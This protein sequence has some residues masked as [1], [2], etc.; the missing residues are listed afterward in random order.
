MGGDPDGYQISLV[1]WVWGRV[2]KTR[3]VQGQ[4]GGVGK[5]YS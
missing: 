4:R 2:L 5:T 3:Q 1:M